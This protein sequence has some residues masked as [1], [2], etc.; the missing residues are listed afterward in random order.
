VIANRVIAKGRDGQREDHFRFGTRLAIDFPV[1]VES[2]PLDLSP[3]KKTSLR[4]DHERRRLQKLTATDKCVRRNGRTSLTDEKRM[5]GLSGVIKWNVS[6]GGMAPFVWP[7]IAA[8]NPHFRRPE[9]RGRCWVSAIAATP[10]L[11]V[12]SLSLS[13]KETSSSRQMQGEQ[14]SFAAFPSSP[15]H[16]PQATILSGRDDAAQLLREL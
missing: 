15:L 3:R 10:P 6:R 11:Q 12:F 16:D 2:I 4:V 13:L 1:R 7:D 14:R 9:P 5:S 8:T